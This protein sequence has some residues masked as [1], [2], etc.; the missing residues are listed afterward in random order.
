MLWT[1]FWKTNN[2]NFWGSPFFFYTARLFSHASH[3]SSPPAPDSKTR[4]F[5]FPLAIPTTNG[6]NQKWK[7]SW[8]M[9]T[10]QTCFC[11]FGAD[12]YAQSVLINK[13]SALELS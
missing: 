12:L 2:K 13:I 8:N 3:N 9:Y 7:L 4:I 5:F 10:L 11:T 1:Y 6:G